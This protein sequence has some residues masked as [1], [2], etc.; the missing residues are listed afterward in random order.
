MSYLSNPGNIIAYVAIGVG[1]CILLIS[2]WLKYR[3]LE[4]LKKKAKVALQLA[5]DGWSLYTVKGCHWCD[6]QKSELGELALSILPVIDCL[7]PDAMANDKMCKLINTKELG[8]PMWIKPKPVLNQK[9]Q[10]PYIVKGY[11]TIEQLQVMDVLNI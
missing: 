9:E 2:V 6:K 11:Q 8:Y 1:I 5:K 4:Q 7:S 10:E 3:V